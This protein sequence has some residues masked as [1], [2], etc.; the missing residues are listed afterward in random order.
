M[1]KQ[2]ESRNEFIDIKPALKKGLKYWYI[3]VIS[4][5]FCVGIGFVYCKLAKPTCQSLANILIK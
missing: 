1:S 2:E 5:V 4:A 3:F